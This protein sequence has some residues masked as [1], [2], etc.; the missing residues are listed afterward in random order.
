MCVQKWQECECFINHSLIHQ[1]GGSYYRSEVEETFEYKTF[2]DAILH[3]SLQTTSVP[4]WTIDIPPS[5][6]LLNLRKI[7]YRLNSLQH[8]GRSNPESV[9]SCCCVLRALSLSATSLCGFPK[10]M[11]MINLNSM[12]LQM[13]RS[14]SCTKTIPTS[15]PVKML[16]RFRMQFKIRTFSHQYWPISTII[17]LSVT[18]LIFLEG[19]LVFTSH[20]VY[21]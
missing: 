17:F 21:I 2:N 14:L 8:F 4:V 18:I 16:C 13:C 15:C 10:L 20:L 5:G 9:E 3:W 11:M 19:L 6:I 12:H 7:L 1:Q